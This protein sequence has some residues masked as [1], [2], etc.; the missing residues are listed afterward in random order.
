MST[1]NSLAHG[2]GFH[3]YREAFNDD[4]VYLEIEG[5]HFEAAYNRVMLPIPV[6]IWELIRRYPGASYEHADK[7]DDELRDE[8]EHAVDERIARFREAKDQGKPLAGL[9]GRIMFGSVEASR[10]EQITMGLAHFA[11][12][13]EHQRQIRQAVG[14]LEE[15]QRRSESNGPESTS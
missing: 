6:H 4:N 5:T 3:L 13:R 7:T 2:P 12:I 11:R 1:K 8:V 10:D 15:Q 9:L 14:E